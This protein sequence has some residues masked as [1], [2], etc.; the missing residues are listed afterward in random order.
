MIA[1][2]RWSA[3]CWTSERSAVPILLAIATPHS[4]SAGRVPATSRSPA[5]YTVPPAARRGPIIGCVLRPIAT[6]R[7]R[8]HPER[9][10]RRVTAEFLVAALGHEVA[11][12]DVRA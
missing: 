12:A 2:R 6:G 3:T 7:S 10:E 11:V 9:L 1:S 4:V 5:V 8:R